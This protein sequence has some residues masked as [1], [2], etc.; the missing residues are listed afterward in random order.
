VFAVAPL[1]YWEL[2]PTPPSTAHVC[3]W[4]EEHGP[5]ESWP[6]PFH[7]LPKLP[8]VEQLPGCVTSPVR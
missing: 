1:R 7:P 4:H 5:D 2:T 8:G 6:R 3:V